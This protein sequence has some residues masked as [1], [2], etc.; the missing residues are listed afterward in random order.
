MPLYTRARD[1]WSVGLEK[2]ER[3]FYTYTKHKH[4]RQ[5]RANL[6]RALGHDA[7]EPVEPLVQ[8]LARDRV[9]RLHE[10]GVIAPGQPRRGGTAG[11]LG[12]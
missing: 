7:G 9:G 10:P 5:N 3:C 12:K 1:R 11:G 2:L 6:R 8:P 4:G